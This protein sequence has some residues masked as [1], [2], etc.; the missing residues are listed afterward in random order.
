MAEAARGPLA[1][2][3]TRIDPDRVYNMFDGRTRRAAG[4]DLVGYGN[5]FVGRGNDL[6]DFIDRAPRLFRV[7]DPV[8]RNLSDPR[9]D[10]AGFFSALERTTRTVAPVAR[11]YARTFK[12]QA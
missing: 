3:R 1:K 8:M 12:E 6:H 4:Q 9:T 10:L 11:T 5:A 7:L 2:T